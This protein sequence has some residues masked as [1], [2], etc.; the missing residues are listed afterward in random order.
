MKK[1]DIR[2]RVLEL[3]DVK[4]EV[5]SIPEWDMEFTVKSLN[6]K[7]RDK[8]ET[9]VFQVSK[10]GQMVFN[11]DNLRAKLIA[12]TVIDEDGDLVFEQSDV[13]ALGNK[14]ASALDKLY[15]VA[16]RLSGLN[17]TAVVNAEKN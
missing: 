16:E 14:N 12:L 4:T 5:I 1:S 9:S 13:E 2:K 8:Y 17:K 7:E 10:N 11:R 6:G 3:Q 15:E